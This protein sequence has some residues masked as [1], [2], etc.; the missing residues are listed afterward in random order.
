MRLITTA[1]WLLASLLWLPWALLALRL[2]LDLALFAT[3]YGHSWSSSPY[4]AP[5][6]EA[7]IIAFRWPQWDGLRPYGGYLVL[8]AGSVFVWCALAGCALGAL[9]WRLYWLAEEGRLRH[10]SLPIVIS[11]LCPPLAVWLMYGDARRRYY[12]AERKLAA[13]RIDAQHRL[14]RG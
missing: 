14:E 9:G 5:V 1:L 3:P 7:L 10:G 6:C 12:A 13:D 8:R 11:S 2:L 4:L